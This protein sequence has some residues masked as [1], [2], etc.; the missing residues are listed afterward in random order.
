MAAQSLW[1]ALGVGAVLTLACVAFADPLMTLLGGGGETAEL[2]AR[3]LRISALGLPFAL[4][5]LSGQGFLRG[6][7]GMRTA[8]IVVVIANV[9]NAILEVVLVYGF[10]LG[11]DGS[12]A[13]TVVAQLGMGAAFAWI[14]LRASARSRRPNPELLRR[15]GR[16]GGHIVVRTGSLLLSFTIAGAV[17]ARIGEDSLAAHQIAF[18]L[19][20]FLALV[21]DAVAIAGQ[22][23]VGRALGAGDA[24]G[25]FAA[26]RRMCAWS[27]AAGAV[28]GLA[29]LASTS[30]LPAAFTSDDDVIDRAKEIWPLFALLQLPGA[31]VFALD[32]I[33]IGAGDTRYL[34]WAMAGTAVLFIPLVLMASSIVGVWW[35]L[36]VLMLSRLLATGLRFRSRRWA[37]VGAAA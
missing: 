13:G 21:L 33:L 9:A 12:A 8:L 17:L 18:Q 15:L 37:V 22:V 16:M 14:L 35:A 3:Y 7:G 27:L 34:A 26:A 6:V 4:V 24:E 32:G 29:L 19:F 28:L 25:A 10:D 11:L 1:L 2:A 20:V 30:L 23:I 31:L 36:Q 5:A